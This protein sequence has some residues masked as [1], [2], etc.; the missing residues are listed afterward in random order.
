[1]A[2]GIQDDVYLKNEKIRR[3]LIGIYVAELGR[4][5]PLRVIYTHDGF[6]LKKKITRGHW[7]FE[8]EDEVTVVEIFRKVALIMLQLHQYDAR[9]LPLPISLSPSDVAGTGV[10][11]A[12]YREL[13]T[14][15]PSLFSLFT[16]QEFK[17][18]VL[19]GRYLLLIDLATF[20]RESYCKSGVMTDLKN[21]RQSQINYIL[22][23]R[24]G[25]IDDDKPLHKISRMQIME[26]IHSCNAKEI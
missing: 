24:S 19:N 18:A 13:M 23:C 8:D 16:F 20:S 12:F 10:I 17:S 11:C 3:K 21:L 26:F 4:A 15:V 22:F 25:L 1:M 14:L 9:A 7:F 2:S 5:Y 6:P